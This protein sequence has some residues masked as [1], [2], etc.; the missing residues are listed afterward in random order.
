MSV[1][2]DQSKKRQLEDAVP[3]DDADETAGK[4]AT[5]RAKRGRQLG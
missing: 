2:A 5:P 4:A 1:S 3:Q